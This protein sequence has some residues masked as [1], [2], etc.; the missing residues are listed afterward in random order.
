MHIVK[1]ALSG[2]GDKLRLTRKG[3]RYDPY[4][5]D[6]IQTD[7]VRVFNG[8][9]N[10]QLNRGAITEGRPDGRIDTN[11]VFDA[12]DWNLQPPVWSFRPATPAFGQMDLDTWVVTGR[13]ETI[14]G[15]S[16]DVL[17]R[18]T[19]PPGGEHLIYITDSGDRRIVRREYYAHKVPIVQITVTYAESPFGL[20]CDSWTI[21]ER[22]ANGALQQTIAVPKVTLKINESL[23]PAHFELE[24]GP[25]TII[26][27]RQTKDLAIVRDDGTLRPVTRGELASGQTW[28]E[29]KES[30]P[31]PEALQSTQGN[32]WR[33]WH[34]A[35]TFA[36]ALSLM[37]WYWRGR[38]S[39]R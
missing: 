22:L 34:Y 37:I 1:Y 26:R 12:S 25:G 23:D 11:R 27:Y 4:P 28:D 8:R 20:V 39:R 33:P 6:F 17:E 3:I 31:L 2:D 35:L 15:V 10:R 16:C 14:N 24:F 5:K 32:E 13:R 9:E 30:T 38:S 21:V 19:M 7:I 36:V 18:P 29:L